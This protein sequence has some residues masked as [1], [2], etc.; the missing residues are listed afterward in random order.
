MKSEEVI[1]EKVIEALFVANGLLEAPTNGNFILKKK[2]A[3]FSRTTSRSLY[4]TVSAE[5]IKAWQDSKSLMKIH[6]ENIKDKKRKKICK[7]EIRKRLIQQV[8]K[9]KGQ[10]SKNEHHQTRCLRRCNTIIKIL[11]KELVS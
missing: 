8:E 7:D 2:D 9:I 11:K 6:C 5:I 4:Q 10:C 1:S 3:P